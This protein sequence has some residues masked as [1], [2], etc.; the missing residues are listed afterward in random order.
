MEDLVPER[1]E[2]FPSGFVN[3]NS[4]IIISHHCLSHQQTM[5]HRP[6]DNPGCLSLVCK[7]TQDVCLWSLSQPRT[8]VSVSSRAEVHRHRTP[9]LLPAELH[10]LPDPAHGR[11]PRPHVRG[12]QGL[13]PVAGPARHQQGA[14]HRKTRS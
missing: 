6:G 3:I 4:I 5:C 11:G 1:Y 10:R 8:S 7:D 2:W 14:A 12:Q 9:L 13:H